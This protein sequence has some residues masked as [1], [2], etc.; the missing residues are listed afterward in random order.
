MWEKPYSTV[1][2]DAVFIWLMQFD[3]RKHFIHTRLLRRNTMGCGTSK[4]AG[5]TAIAPK[6]PEDEHA[7]NAQACLPAGT[8]TANRTLAMIKPDAVKCTSLASNCLFCC[9]Q[10]NHQQTCSGLHRTHLWEYLNRFSIQRV[11]KLKPHSTCVC[12]R[13]AV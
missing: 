9:F 1:P 7:S 10:I 6:Q 3:G 5:D 2:L 4:T 11:R 12:T 13:M 8:V